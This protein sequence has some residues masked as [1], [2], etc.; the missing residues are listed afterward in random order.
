MRPQMTPDLARIAPIALALAV[1]ATPG[2]DAARAGGPAVREVRAIDGKL[3]PLVP[4]PG[5]VTA[6]VFYS[7]ECPISNGYSPTLAALRDSHPSAKF[8]MVGV[9]VDAELSA[10]DVAKHAREYGLNFPVAVDRDGTISARFGVKMTPEAVVLDDSGRGPL[11]GADRRPVRRP[12]QAERRAPDRRVARGGRGRPG[13]QGGRR[14][15]RRGRRLPDP[16]PAPR[17]KAGRPTPA[18]SPRSSRT[19]AWNATG[20]ARSARSRWP[21]TSRPASGPGRSPRR[22]PSGGCRPG[23]RTPASA[24][25]SSTPRPSPPTRSPPWPPGPRRAPPS[26]NLAEVPSPPTFS[27]GWALGEPDLVIEAPEDFAIPASGEDIYRCFVIP[28]NLPTTSTSP[29]SST[30]RATAR[31]STTSSATWTPAARGGRRTRPTTRP[32]TCASAVP[33]SSRSTATSAAG[34]PAASRRSCPTGSAG[35]CPKAPT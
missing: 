21:P 11:S 22:P 7:T 2:I 34:P 33:A 20:P 12:G 29:R 9:C 30:G 28:T 17:P 24:C 5:G 35:A 4:D 26:G 15:P 13:G 1:L 16:R 8:R 18:T 14:R 31:S 10:A 23:R 19:T 27:T 25:P 32:A 6:V 3:V